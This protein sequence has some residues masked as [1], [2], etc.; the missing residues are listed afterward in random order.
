MSVG[1][2][3]LFEMFPLIPLL[4]DFC[5]VSD[6]RSSKRVLTVKKLIVEGTDGAVG[7]EEDVAGVPVLKIHS[8]ID[9]NSRNDTAISKESHS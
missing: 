6:A 9:N 1:V 2:D 7:G 3:R 5:I 8:H 4:D